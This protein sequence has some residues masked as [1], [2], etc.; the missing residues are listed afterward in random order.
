MQKEKYV[1]RWI[2]W[3]GTTRGQSP[4]MP[5]FE[6][7]PGMGKGRWVICSAELSADFPVS[8]PSYTSP[9][10]ERSRVLLYN[11]SAGFF[12][13]LVRLRIC[14]RLRR[15]RKRDAQDRYRLLRSFGLSSLRD[16]WMKIQFLGWVDISHEA[17]R[18]CQ[19]G[20]VRSL[21][22]GTIPS[23]QSPILIDSPTK[24]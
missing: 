11:S 12:L 6:I 19:L 24:R 2:G 8:T 4:A 14:A 16:A 15:S 18:P 5:L 10:I 7:R 21:L 13:S 20:I 17:W 1:G 3:Q 22:F 9:R 23:L